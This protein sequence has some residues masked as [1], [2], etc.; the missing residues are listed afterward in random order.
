MKKKLLVVVFILG[1]ST[2]GFCAGNVTKRLNIARQEAKI[3]AKIYDAVQ[4]LKV[5]KDTY[6][7]LG[8]PFVDSDFQASEAIDISY[9]NA[10]NAGALLSNVTP[11]LDA[12]ILDSGNGNFNRNVM[13]AVRK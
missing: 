2:P 7:A 4:E 9:M 8:D 10:Y 5:L 11:A 3:A 12:V 6:A 13:L 1:I